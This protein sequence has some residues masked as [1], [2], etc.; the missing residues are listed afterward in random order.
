MPSGDAET[1]LTPWSVL[2]QRSWAQA[3]E[4]LLDPEGRWL[5]SAHRRKERHRQ[6]QRNTHRHA[7]RDTQTERHSD[8]ETW[9]HRRW[10]GFGA[11]VGVLRALSC[12]KSRYFPSEALLGSFF[13][14][15]CPISLPS[16][17]CQGSLG[18]QIKARWAQ[19]SRLSAAP[20]H[21]CPAHP[22]APCSRT[23]S[24]G[25]REQSHA[26]GPC[27]T[28]QPQFPPLPLQSSVVSEAK[29]PSRPREGVRG[30]T[31]V[32]VGALE[33]WWRWG[34]PN[35]RC[36]PPSRMDPFAD[37]LQRLREAFVSGRTRP[38]KFRA[39]QLKGLSLFLQENKQLLQEALAQDLYKVGGAGVRGGGQ[40]WVR[41]GRGE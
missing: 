20:S 25:H 38:A 36:P 27:G 22:I 39:A 15:P 8:R 5:T 24:P 12:S 18:C 2:R 28:P 26:P 3:C 7:Q 23:T 11:L 31:W 40:G 17:P 29:N 14:P 6:T 32:R 35:R 4:M 9:R 19:G 16:Q 41:A 34:H 10:Y 33:G 1:C 30:P 37:T 21:G 13:P